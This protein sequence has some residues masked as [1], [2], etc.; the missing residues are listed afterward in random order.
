MPERD[1]DGQSYERADHNGLDRQVDVLD[2]ARRDPIRAL[3]VG[4]IDQPPP[5]KE[6]KVHRIRQ[7][8]PMAQRPVEPSQREGL[9]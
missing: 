5:D 9:P 3:P 6:E 4:G 7:A 1:A 8:A 2:E